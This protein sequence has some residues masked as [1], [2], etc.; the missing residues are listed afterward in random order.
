MA[1]S[2]FLWPRVV[3]VASGWNMAVGMGACLTACNRHG[4]LCCTASGVQWSQQGG[5]F[6]REACTLRLHSW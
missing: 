1:G 4:Q 5:H 3:F 6:M 2:A